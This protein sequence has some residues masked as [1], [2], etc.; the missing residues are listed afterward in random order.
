MPR[1][2]APRPSAHSVGGA[3]LAA[4]RFAALASLALGARADSTADG[5]NV[6]AAII[7]TLIGLYFVFSGLGAYSRRL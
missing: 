5:G 7:G 1:P 3:P 4:A 6:L 2:V